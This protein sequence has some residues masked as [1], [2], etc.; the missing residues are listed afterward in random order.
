[1]PSP[2]L[3]L[4]FVFAAAIAIG[5]ALLLG[6]VVAT[7]N[8]ALELYQRISDLPV[9]LRFPLIALTAAIVIAA[10]WLL[11]RLARPAS[12]TSLAGTPAVSR[13]EIEKRLDALRERRAETAALEAE[14]VDLD[15]RRSSGDLHVAMFGEIS[16]GKSSV[17]RALAP[18]SAVDV[19]VRGGTTR[20]V[21]Q[22]DGT[23]PDHRLVDVPHHDA[24]PTSGARRLQRRPRVPAPPSRATPAVPA[25][26]RG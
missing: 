4:R 14:L 15:R 23:D 7:L 20:T 22:H 11:W 25:S 6:L 17:I 12:R 13:T 10:A 18:D 3:P 21:A 9:W 1:M 16:T 5:A 8:G 19:D 26:A 2:R 24:D